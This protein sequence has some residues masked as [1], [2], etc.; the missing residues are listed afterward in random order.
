MPAVAGRA[1]KLEGVAVDI[2]ARPS[3]ASAAQCRESRGCG[4]HVHLERAQEGAFPDE[5]VWHG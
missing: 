2:T 4:R 5:E 3:A 1:A